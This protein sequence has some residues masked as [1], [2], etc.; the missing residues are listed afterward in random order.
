MAAFYNN[1]EG[2]VDGAT[3]ATT[4][5]G[6]GN[7][8]TA[9]T[10]SGTAILQYQSVLKRGLLGYRYA[11]RGDALVSHMGWDSG[12]DLSVSYGRFYFWID[13]LVDGTTYL[14]R[15]RDEIGGSIGIYL[16]ISAAEQV[17][18]R[19][20]NDTLNTTLSTTLSINTEYRLEYFVQCLGATANVQVR[21]YAGE[22]STP[23][24]DTG[25]VSVNQAA[26]FLDFSVVEHGMLNTAT[27]RPSA[28]GY[29][30]MDDIA[31]FAPTWPGQGTGL[32][33]ISG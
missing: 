18:I 30:Y 33:W 31:A 27:N 4:D 2:G 13:T 23:L 29:V 12:L 17:Q 28:T 3:V 21:L 32:A 14:M 15:T 16:A 25:I 8:W 19:N 7:Q 9:V 5:T 1:A 24:T 26:S 20:G 6:S 22:S 11:T 10:T